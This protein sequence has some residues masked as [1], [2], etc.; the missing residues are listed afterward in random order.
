MLENDSGLML[1]KN[2]DRTHGITYSIPSNLNTLAPI[3]TNAGN[4]FAG[5]YPAGTV[6]NAYTGQSE[7]TYNT[8][9]ITTPPFCGTIQPT[10]TGTECGYTCVTKPLSSY[11]PINTSTNSYN[12]PIVKNQ[13]FGEEE[14]ILV[15]QKFSYSLVLDGNVAPFN[16]NRQCDCRCYCYC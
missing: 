16:Q 10:V 12:L 15:P 13:A 14:P 11:L 8:G 2:G 3:G 6:S 5:T 1:H 9:S 4:A 7:N